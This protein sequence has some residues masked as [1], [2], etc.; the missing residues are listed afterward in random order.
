MNDEIDA[1]R[2]RELGEEGSGRT[3]VGDPHVA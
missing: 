2:R 3:R 1:A